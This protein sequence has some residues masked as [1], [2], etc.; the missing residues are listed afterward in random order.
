MSNHVIPEGFVRCAF[1][2]PVPFIDNLEVYSRKEGWKQTNRTEYYVFTNLRPDYK[3]LVKP[4]EYP[5]VLKP[6]KYE[7]KSKTNISF[8]C[9]KSSTSFSNILYSVQWGDEIRFILKQ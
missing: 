3:V 7:N 4:E 8:Y 6:E 1:E 2:V 5:I 9:Y